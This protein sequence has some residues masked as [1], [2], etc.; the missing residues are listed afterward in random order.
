MRRA[1][2]RDAADVETVV[3]LLDAYARDPFGG[4]HALSDAAR[5]ALGPALRDRPGMHALLAFDG[6]APVGLA[7]C[8]EGFSTFAGKPLLNLHDLAV[9][10]DARG[11]GAG[12]ALMDAV[13]ALATSIG[14]CKVTLEVL[15]GN[16]TAQALY[17]RAGFAPYALDAQHGRATFW[18]R[19]IAA[20]AA[21]GD[22]APKGAPQS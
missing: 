9:R 12:R 2:P 19:W 22:I 18:Q 1:D 20:D 17:A 21:V 5:Q 6:A 3:A 13:V 15:E 16:T 14:C 4:A 11:R 10:A 7:I 8:I